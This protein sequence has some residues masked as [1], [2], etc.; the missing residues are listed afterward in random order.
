MSSYISLKYNQ[1]D[2]GMIKLFILTSWPKSKS[3][4]PSLEWFWSSNAISLLTE[5]LVVFG[6]YWSCSPSS[7][8]IT[9]CLPFFIIIS[10]RLSCTVGLQKGRNI[11]FNVY[12]NQLFR[13]TVTKACR[14]VVHDADFCE[15]I[16]MTKINYRY[17][18][19]LKTSL[20]SQKPWL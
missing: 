6:T 12:W 13:T 11:N 16:Q 5:R 15:K 20:V 17:Q 2:N 8:S 19:L 4:I 7:T 10:C 9:G 3:E 1:A 18:V 14:R